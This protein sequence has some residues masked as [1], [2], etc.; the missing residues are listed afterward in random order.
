M[1]CEQSREY[2]LDHLDNELPATLQQELSEH[3]RACASCRE[4]LEEYRKTAL[5]LQLRAVPEP[6]EEYWEQSWSKIRARTVARVLPL[7]PAQIFRRPAWQ[8]SNPLGWPARFAIAALLLIALA[9]VLATLPKHSQNLSA[10]PMSSRMVHPAQRVLN[11]EDM[12]PEMQRQIELLTFTSAA[13]GALDPIS[14][15]TTKIILARQD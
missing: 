15:G 2:L 8:T 1:T 13:A 14:K 12:P 9:G 11:P 10:R 5:L 3:I 7:N 6:P 4:E